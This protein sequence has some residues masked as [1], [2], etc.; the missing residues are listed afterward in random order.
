MRQPPERDEL[1]PGSPDL[2]CVGCLRGV[3]YCTQKRRH[4]EESFGP[5]PLICQLRRYLFPSAADRADD[6]CARNEHVGE[7]NLRKMGLRIEGVDREDLDAVC[8]EIHDQLTEA[9]VAVS[10]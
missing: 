10:S 9:K 7:N 5:A 4:A 3:G 1:R 2:L 6:V 8:A